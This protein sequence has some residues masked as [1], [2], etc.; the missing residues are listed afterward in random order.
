MIDAH[1]LM[2]SQQF[3]NLNAKLNDEAK[4][5]PFNITF[6]ITFFFTI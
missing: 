5:F 4:F 6:K 1:F 2:I 3:I